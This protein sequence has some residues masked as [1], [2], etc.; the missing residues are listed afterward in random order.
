MKKIVAMLMTVSVLGISAIQSLRADIAYQLASSGVYHPSGSWAGGPWPV[1][2]FLYQGIW[3]ELVPS[4]H[5]PGPGGSLLNGGATEFI[6]FSRAGV[7]DYGYIQYSDTPDE[8]TQND[9]SDVGGL[10][11]N[12]GFLYFRLFATPTAASP[13][14][15]GF[16]QSP[17]I[18]T[19]TLDDVDLSNPPINP[20]SITQLNATLG[21]PQ[22]LFWIPEPKTL[23]LLM[24]SAFVFTFLKNRLF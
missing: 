19:S 17:P 2:G 5:W 11:I 12:N 24:L 23:A 21:V 1:V 4:N 6:L 20:G 9:D 3:S 13:L 18:H 14:S 15:E 10:N 22:P 16:Y 7:H 8:D